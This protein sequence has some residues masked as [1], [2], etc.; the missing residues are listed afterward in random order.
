MIAADDEHELTGGNMGPVTRRGRQV[1]RT[2]GPWT[3]AVH[4]L[5]E[6]CRAAGMDAVPR[7]YG[8]EADGREVL[9]Y[10]PG[11]VPAYPMPPWVW[12]RDALTSSAA[13]LRRFHDASA[14]ADRTGPWRFEPREP[15]EVVCHSDFAP[16]NLVFRDGRAT[17]IIDL[18]F[19]APGPRIWDLA[20][21]A[22]RVV[23][24]S[25]DRADTFTDRERLDRLTLLLEAYSG[26]DPVAG[27]QP[28]TV[29]A[30]LDTAIGRLQVLADLS[31]QQA[32][33]QEKPELAEHADLYDL[34]SDYI[35]SFRRPAAFLV[36]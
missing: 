10:L 2:S 28:M 23:P 1:L 18:D 8:I 26:G 30:I 34:D 35:R 14:S 29:T 16:Y 13:L 5:L 17:G 25:T 15:A 20:Y 33:E 32:V 3:Q 19:A 6:H 9:E 22:Y 12:G 21:L 4:R 31:R 36:R 27:A 24:L 11:T 7:P